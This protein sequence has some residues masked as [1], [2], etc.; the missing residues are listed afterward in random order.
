[1]MSKWNRF[2][3]S[4]SNDHSGCPEDIKKR[5]YQ[6]TNHATKKELCVSQ[7]SVFVSAENLSDLSI[8]KR[9]A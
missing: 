9:K 2:T 5:K 4:L 1:M 3:S 7:N 6:D 8:N